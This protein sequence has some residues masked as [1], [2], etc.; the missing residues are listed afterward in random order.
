MICWQVSNV[1]CIVKIF[2]NVLLWLVFL[3]AHS[4]CIEHSVRIHWTTI[5][6]VLE[7]SGIWAHLA[8]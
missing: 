2:I 8:T 1:T 3:A 5:V 4:I 6:H 7:L